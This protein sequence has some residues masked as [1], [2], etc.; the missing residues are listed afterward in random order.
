VLV[1]ADLLIHIM[2]LRLH[3]SLSAKL[4]QFTQYVRSIFY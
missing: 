2:L 4:N 1:A 3:F